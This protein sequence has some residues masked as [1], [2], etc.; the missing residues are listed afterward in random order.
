MTLPQSHS[1]TGLTSYCSSDSHL[2]SQYSRIPSDQRRL[3]LLYEMRSPKELKGPFESG[4]YLSNQQSP[5]P[6][7]KTSNYLNI[8]SERCLPYTSSSM[9]S[10]QT[11]P[12]IQESNS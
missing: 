4:N 11:M 5:N 2:Y 7:L 6:S 8:P 10:E 1:F 12:M 9:M 3:P